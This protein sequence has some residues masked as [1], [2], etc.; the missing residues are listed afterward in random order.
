MGRSWS[1]DKIYGSVLSANITTDG[2]SPRAPRHET[3][4]TRLAAVYFMQIRTS[5]D[6]RARLH[7]TRETRFPWSCAAQ[8]LFH[9]VPHAAESSR[10]NMFIIITLSRHTDDVR[11]ERFRKTSTLLNF[12]IYHC[13]LQTP[14]YSSVHMGLRKQRDIDSLWRIYKN[15][16][17]KV[18]SVLLAYFHSAVTMTIYDVRYVHTR[19]HAACVPA[20]SLHYMRILSF[21][22]L[23]PYKI[24]FN[25]C[26]Y[27]DTIS[28]LIYKTLLRSYDW[29]YG[30]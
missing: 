9:H 1:R 23:T 6:K 21:F 2:R 14:V 16:S 13:H 5:P 24:L 8:E 19:S 3:R 30:N 26:S 27:K 25:Y 15:F 12:F 18:V 17:A 7:P 28:M 10:D 29:Q 4:L 20:K 22:L 11:R